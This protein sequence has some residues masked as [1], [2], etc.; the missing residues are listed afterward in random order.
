MLAEAYSE[1]SNVENISDIRGGGRVS[2]ATFPTARGIPRRPKH[3][4]GSAAFEGASHVFT[5]WTS[6]FKTSSLEVETI[7]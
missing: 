4:L 6:I 2:C 1:L 3:D 5:E 7:S